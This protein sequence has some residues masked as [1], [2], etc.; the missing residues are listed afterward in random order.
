MMRKGMIYPSIYLYICVAYIY[1]LVSLRETRSTNIRCMEHD[2]A[3]CSNVPSDPLAHIS[4]D[5]GKPHETSTTLPER[6]S[7]T[8]VDVIG[9]VH[10]CNRTSYPTNSRVPGHKRQHWG[11]ISRLHGLK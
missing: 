8:T 5:F 11:R 1:V 7:P 10:W 6:K 3:P 9:P 2:A 4:W